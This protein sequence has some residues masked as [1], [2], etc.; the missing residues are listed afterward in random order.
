MINIFSSTIQISK[1][2]ATGLV[3]I[4]QDIELNLNVR[5]EFSN[6]IGFKN[7]SPMKIERSF[8]P[9]INKPITYSIILLHD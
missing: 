4:W 8:F 5:V 1:P 9:L 6:L 3:K 7:F 2:K